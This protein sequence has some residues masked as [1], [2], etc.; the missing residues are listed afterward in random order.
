M[1][2][3]SEN[4]KSLPTTGKR[5]PA[6]KASSSTGLQLGAI[7]SDEMAKAAAYLAD[8]APWEVERDLQASLTRTLNSPLYFETNERGNYVALR[9]KGEPTPEMWARASKSVSLACEPM[10][11]GGI[12]AE[13]AR[14]RLTTK[15]RGYSENDMKAQSMIY[16]EAMS[17]YPADIAKSVMRRPR[18][19]WPALVELTD[20]A[21]KKA[22]R[23]RWLAELIE[24]KAR[25]N[26]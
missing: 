23:R 10:D 4:L 2:T 26:K 17:K 15:I 9:F 13:I 18:E 5:N 3:L 24:R 12:M 8:H 22:Y 1:K 7:G 21:D 19:W 6:A 11:V 20:E 16:A 25:G 14:M